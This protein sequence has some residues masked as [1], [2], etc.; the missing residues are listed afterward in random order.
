MA[1]QIFPVQ[2]NSN[3]NTVNRNNSTP[4]TTAHRHNCY[5]HR[6]RHQR[7]CFDQQQQWIH[8]STPD[9]QR[10]YF[11]WCV[12][13]QPTQHQNTTE[14]AAHRRRTEPAKRAT[15]CDKLDAS[16]RASRIVPNEGG[17]II[18]CQ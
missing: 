2:L 12:F 15:R 7:W 10:Q 17:S 6:D 8:S 18:L 16:M 4:L 11:R 1:R 5:Y 3:Q 13:T 9:A 14:T